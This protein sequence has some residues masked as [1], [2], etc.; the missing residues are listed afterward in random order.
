MIFEI[1]H[2][3]TGSS[4]AAKRRAKAVK[5]IPILRHKVF[6]RAIH[7]AQR[8]HGSP[9]RR[10]KADGNVPGQKLRPLHSPLH[11]VKSNDTP[12][13]NRSGATH[14]PAPDAAAP[15]AR[16]AP[17]AGG[18]SGGGRRGGQGMASPIPRGNHHSISP[19]CRGTA[20]PLAPRSMGA[21][22]AVRRKRSGNAPPPARLLPPGPG[23]KSTK[24]SGRH[25]TPGR[26]ATGPGAQTRKAPGVAKGPATAPPG[27][28]P[29]TRK[30]P[31]RCCRS[32]NHL[33]GAEGES[34][35]PTGKPPLD[36]EPSVSTNSTTSA[37]GRPLIN[38][39][40]EPL[41]AFFKIFLKSIISSRYQLAFR[42]R[43]PGL[44]HGPF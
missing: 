35:T 33:D 5:D 1:R 31:R 14:H 23:P 41:Q 28:G 25:G 12:Q 24:S 2:M 4:R 44:N 32:P 17:R 8:R 34:R 3:R 20:S 39:S 16:T 26:C 21:E 9:E 37:S 10:R 42:W 13:H 38:P 15:P 30:G 36:P 11:A 29:Q 43:P 18:T 19:A 6:S 27:Q 7:N 22:R 40:F